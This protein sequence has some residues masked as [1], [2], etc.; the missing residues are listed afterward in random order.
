MLVAIMGLVSVEN[1]RHTESTVFRTK[2]FVPML[3]L[4]NTGASLRLREFSA[5]AHAR[6]AAS[7][8]IHDRAPN[9][10][11]TPFGN[12]LLGNFEN[13][14]SIP[15]SILC[16]LMLVFCSLSVASNF[17]SPSFN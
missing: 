1:S 17:V 8:C 3:P 4:T 15:R 16:C 6:G 13:F 9:H 12:S 5:Q 11:S 2:L 14:A 10:G 7:V